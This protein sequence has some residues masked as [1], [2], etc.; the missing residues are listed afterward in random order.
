M[1]TIDVT[2]LNKYY[3]PKLNTKNILKKYLKEQL[4][5]KK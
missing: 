3:K 2:K 1:F 5:K 4:I